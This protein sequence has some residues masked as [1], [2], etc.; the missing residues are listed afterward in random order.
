MGHP[1]LARTVLRSIL[2]HGPDSEASW[3]LSRT[4]VQEGDKAQAMAAVKGAGTYR[5]DNPLQPEP[6][7]YVGEVRCEKCHQAIFRDSLASRHTQTYYRGAQLD[8]L[9]LPYRPLPDP[10][11][12]NVTHTFRRHDGVLTAETRREQRFL[13]R[14]SSMRLG[15]ATAT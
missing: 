13:T 12:P 14:S 7:P 3:L 8:T 15:P 2:D 10:D 9:P 11:D 6:A 1:A 4:Y 5:A